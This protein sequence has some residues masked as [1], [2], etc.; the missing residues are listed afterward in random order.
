MIFYLIVANF[1]MFISFFFTI[2]T[3]KLA[4]KFKITT[5]TKKRS[6]P[7][8]THKGIIPR[9][10]GIPIFLAFLITSLIFIEINKIVFGILLASSFLILMGL[11]DDI[12]DIS[13]YYRFIA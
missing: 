9:G 3:I 2:P 4:K 13:A 5:D 12:Y 11:L 10:G 8:H 7:A 1:V 6:H